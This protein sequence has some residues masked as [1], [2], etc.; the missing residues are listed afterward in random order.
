MTHRRDGLLKCAKSIC[1]TRDRGMST[2][3]S[4]VVSGVLSHRKSLQGDVGLC[5]A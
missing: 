3:H 2:A 1:E 4:P 5:W